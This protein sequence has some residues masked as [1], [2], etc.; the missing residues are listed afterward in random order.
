VTL[1]FILPSYFGS[2]LSGDG[3]AAS[4]AYIHPNPGIGS[5]LVLVNLANDGT[6]QP[7]APEA[8]R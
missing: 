4:L 5:N 3:I 1:E 2:A 8:A 6:V 7:I